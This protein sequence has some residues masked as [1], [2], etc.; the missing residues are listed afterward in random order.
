MPDPSVENL[1]TRASSVLS[2]DFTKQLNMHAFKKV[3]EIAAESL[4]MRHEDA[5]WYT[6][7][8]LRV[9]A[10]KLS[11]VLLEHLS[12][13]QN[14]LPNYE[15]HHTNISAMWIS[16]IIPPLEVSFSCQTKSKDNWL[17]IAGVCLLFDIDINTIYYVKS[18]S[19]QTLSDSTR[20]RF[21]RDEGPSSL[22]AGT[23]NILGDQRSST[24]T[25]KKRHSAWPQINL[26]NFK[27]LIYGYCKGTSLATIARELTK[28][29]NEHLARIQQE[30]PDFRVYDTVIKT[31]FLHHYLK[32]NGQSQNPTL[33]YCDKIMA[34]CIALGADRNEIFN[35]PQK[36]TDY[37]KTRFSEISLTGMNVIA[38]RY[39]IARRLRLSKHCQVNKIAEALNR[40]LREYNVE[41]KSAWLYIQF[42]PNKSGLVS[43]SLGPESETNIRLIFQIIDN[44][45]RT[46]SPA[47][48]G[49]D[50]TAAASTYSDET[51]Q[52]PSKR[53]HSSASYSLPP[54]A[55]QLLFYQDR[56]PS[57]FQDSLPSEE[58]SAMPFQS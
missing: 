16:Y 36:P 38:L 11:L 25:A 58:T 12:I 6:A 2:I 28:L 34:I 56:S 50:A 26:I 57:D 33:R 21:G 19:T 47:M 30:I 40:Y 10:E 35:F 32:S 45:N 4:N 3:L 9:L 17:K 42:N 48:G 27:Q 24:R 31:N 37:S 54:S 20:K 52:P 41:I 22:S 5:S 13:I 29:L 53:Q 18:A 8:W 7:G 51:T 46:E 44:L 23:P 15:K 39:E 55:T 49:V 43:G 1:T 14:Q